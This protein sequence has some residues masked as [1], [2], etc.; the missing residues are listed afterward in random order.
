MPNPFNEKTSITFYLP[1]DCNVRISVYNL[2]G[3]VI[4]ELVSG[5]YVAGKYTVEFDASGLPSGNYFYKFVSDEF[6]TTKVMNL[7]K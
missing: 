6:V 2:L 4:E 3:D 5:Q 7:N 1:V